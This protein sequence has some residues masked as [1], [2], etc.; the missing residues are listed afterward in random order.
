MVEVHG[1][2]ALSG[3]YSFP[4]HA[5]TTYIVPISLEAKNERY[6]VYGGRSKHLQEEL[7]IT[8]HIVP[9]SLGHGDEG[10]RVYGG[11]SKYLQEE[12]GRTMH[13]IPLSLGAR[14]EGYQVY[15]GKSNCFQEEIDITRAHRSSYPFTLRDTLL[16]SSTSTNVGYPRK[17][18]VRSMDIVHSSL[19]AR[20]EGYF[21]NVYGGS[22]NNWQE[23]LDRTT[24]QRESYSFD[25]VRCDFERY[26]TK[27]LGRFVQSR[28]NILMKER[29]VF[30]ES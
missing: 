29:R 13:T 6:K 22:S 25:G 1:R 18:H 20:N 19:G 30:V 11:R 17:D 10:Y 4:D 24:A 21:S 14:N 3:G 5:G 28:M 7:G 23:E 9:L 27:V 26:T 8:M 16:K 2:V 12:L 15:G